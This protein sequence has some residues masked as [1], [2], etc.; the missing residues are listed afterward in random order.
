MIR[1]WDELS[2]QERERLV[3]PWAR[4]PLRDKRFS[5]GDDYAA[6][7]W[8]DAAGQRRETVVGHDPNRG[9]S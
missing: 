6:D 7:G 2:P 5:R 3:G 1:L 9:Q 8:V 4:D